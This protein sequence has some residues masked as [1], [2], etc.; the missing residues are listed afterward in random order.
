V[1]K[2]KN[3]NIGGYVCKYITKMGG[4]SEEALAFIWR[5]KIRLYSYSRCYKLPTKDKE[6]SEWAYLTSTTRQG[7]EDNLSMILRAR[8]NIENLEDYLEDQPETPVCQGRAQRG[9]RRALTNK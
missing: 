3:V 1:E 2:A 6:T 9:R 8:P 7:I 5:R 4:W